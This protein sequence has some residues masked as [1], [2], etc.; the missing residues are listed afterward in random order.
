M[1]LKHI[2]PSLI[3]LLVI[4]NPFFS[5]AATASG[6]IDCSVTETG[7]I[8]LPDLGSNL[9]CRD[10][11]CVEGGLYPEGSPI[12]P[13]SLEVEAQRIANQIQ[14]LD[15]NG[16]VDLVN[17]KIV[18]ISV[19]M[20]NTS[21]AFED[22]APN[23]Q[24]TAFVPR[25]N[26][27]PAKN[28]QLILINGALG[29]E[30]ADSWEDPNASS[31]TAVVQR[32]DSYNRINRG[33]TSISPEQVQVAW[34]KQAMR[35]T[36]LF[37]NYAQELQGY[38]EAI[39]RN[40]KLHFP[41]IKIAFYSSRTY[42]YTEFRKGEPDTYEGGFAIRWMIEKQLNGDPSL[43]YDLN[44]GK[45]NAPLLLWGPYFWTDGLSPRSDGLIWVCGEGEDMWHG[46]HP[47][48]AGAQKNAD[49]IYA[50][51]KT[52]PA[53]TPWYLRKNAVGQQPIVSVYAIP[54]SG[55][56]PL[57]VDFTASASSVDGQVIEYVWTFG[58]G[59]FSFNPSGT[60]NSPPY[61]LNQNP[62]K[63]FYTPG[64][65]K[66]YLT[67]TDNLGNAVT[68]TVTVNVSA[69]YGEQLQSEPPLTEETEPEQL[70]ASS[71]EQDNQS[72]SR[73]PANGYTEGLSSL[74][75]TAEPV[76]ASQT[77]LSWSVEVGH[78]S[79]Y[80][81]ERKVGQDG[82][83][84]SI[85]KVS[86]ETNSYSDLELQPNTLY[87]YRLR[88]VNFNGEETVSEVASVT[89]DAILPHAISPSKQEDS[90]EDNGMDFVSLPDDMQD[91]PTQDIGSYWVMGLTLPLIGL[92]LVVL[93][94]F[95]SRMKNR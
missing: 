59:T 47:E 77:E 37:P 79:G 73:L 18:M 31:W 74:I 15:I 68:E 20:S 49:Q 90:T 4:L 65:Y 39:A 2:I 30:A 6:L 41:N 51:F 16:N 1:P 19:G 45:V 36:G 95:R 66:V 57:T 12:R 78:P 63:K 24:W 52:D 5:P 33:I 86:P 70:P 94:R 62:T 34:V 81:I 14:P 7:K 92:T 32:I 23:P 91:E 35:H 25:A 64:I 84:L 17:G 54:N 72:S 50:F 43:N 3:C 46:I 38:L 10:G 21:M 87:S 44:K 28:P 82:N 75:L 76:S 71:R 48:P 29:G 42:A 13:Q 8:P 58:D 67:V 56:A 89:T 22:P 27:D 53:A 80:K 61:Y 26:S 55:P 93:H 85:T 60:V 9:Y 40:L 69:P 11:H 83:W 88:F